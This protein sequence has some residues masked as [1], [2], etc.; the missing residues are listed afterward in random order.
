MN[1]LLPLFNWKMK[2]ID[3]LGNRLSL[4]HYIRSDILFV[5]KIII[6]RKC[7]TFLNSVEQFNFY[8]INICLIR[9]LTTIQTFWFCYGILKLLLN[10]KMWCVLWKL[11][12]CCSG[13][14][15]RLRYG[16]KREGK[17]KV[18]CYL[19]CTVYSQAHNTSWPAPLLR[20]FLTCI[21]AKNLL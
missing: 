6:M 14:L 3:T 4:S 16:I 10:F 8:I 19:Q 18:Q 17:A 5:W 20:P 15:N 21:I 7:K 12:Q 11:R 2:W 1:S 9:Y 13:L